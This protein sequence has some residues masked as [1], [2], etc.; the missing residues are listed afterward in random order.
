MGVTRLLARAGLTAAVAFGMAACGGSALPASDTTETPSSDT[1]AR[2]LERSADEMQRELSKLEPQKKPDTPDADT[3]GVGQT[4]GEE[5]GGEVPAAPSPPPPAPESAAT[6]AR[7][8]EEPSPRQRCETACRALG[9]MKRTADRI[10]EI[11]GDTHE[12]CT[13]ARGRVS[14]AT[15]RVERAGCECSSS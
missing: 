8:E 7:D 1:L 14:D 10:C 4:G 13:W 12:K 11:V 6:D 2:E 15:E 9:S 3:G 5:T